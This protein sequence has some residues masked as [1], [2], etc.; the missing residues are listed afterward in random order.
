MSQALCE[1]GYPI[2]PIPPGPERDRI[3]AEVIRAWHVQ[4]GIPPSGVQSLAE[5]STSYTKS[6]QY[7]NRVYVDI[8]CWR[9]LAWNLP[10]NGRSYDDCGR[11]WHD[12]GLGCLNTKKHCDSNVYVKLTAATCF[13]SMCP[14][15]F[16]KWASREAYRIEEKFMR[17]TRNNA[18]ARVPTITCDSCQIVEILKEGEKLK[19]ELAHCGAVLLSHCPKSKS[20]LGR[21][22][23]VV[24]SV[25]EWDSHLMKDDFSALRAKVYKIAKAVGVVG[26]AAV[27]H[28]FAN[29]K[30]TPKL[31]EIAQIDEKT[32]YFDLKSLRA[33]YR[34]IGKADNFWFERPHF[35]LLAYAPRDFKNPKKDCLTKEKVRAVHK[36]TGYVIK[37]LGLRTDYNLEKKSGKDGS[38]KRTAQYLL[39]HAGVKQG[40]QTVSWFGRLSN[41]M[42]KYENPRA[43]RNP[44]KPTCPECEAVLKP[45]R[46]DP[47]FDPEYR[48]LL[49]CVL[50]PNDLEGVLMRERISPL[51]GFKEGGYWTPAEHWRYVLDG[52]VPNHSCLIRPPAEGDYVDPALYADSGADLPYAGQVYL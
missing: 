5:K 18:E 43:E 46:Y 24:I 48:L 27:F 12:E 15:C 23:H 51:E 8:K 31:A 38:V 28:P 50:A 1:S 25:P 7:E 11:I 42:Y 33:Y 22:V 35:H 26:G 40:V 39:S 29:D 34:K 10:G 3:L 37:N 36:K 16:Q 6:I 2:H 52:E 45:V 13:L 41:R 44:P 20:R 47:P 4:E 32:G 30:V 9:P 21:V 49:A 17:L 14:I 19:G